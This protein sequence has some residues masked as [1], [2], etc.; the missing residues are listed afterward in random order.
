MSKIVDVAAAV[1]LRESGGQEYLLAQRPPGKVYAG[2]WEFQAVE[3][4]RVGRS[5]AARELQE[6][7][8][9]EVTACH[10]RLRRRSPIRTPRCVCISGR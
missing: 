2:Y 5:I 6:E 1:L 4:R 8:G 3:T 10:L 7:L 9:I